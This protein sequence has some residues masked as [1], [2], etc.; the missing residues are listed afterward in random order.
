MTVTSNDEK[1][2]KKSRDTGLSG[3]SIFS[4][5]LNLDGSYLGLGLALTVFVSRPRIS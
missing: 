5:S 2:D 3:K 1:N 4:I